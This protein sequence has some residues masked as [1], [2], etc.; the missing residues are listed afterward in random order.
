[1][2]NNHGKIAQTFYDGS[3]RERVVSGA[4]TRIFNELSANSL[5]VTVGS[6]PGNK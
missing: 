3:Q 4:K 1:V 2:S 5:F 6:L